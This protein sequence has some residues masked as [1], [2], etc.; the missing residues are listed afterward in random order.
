MRRRPERRLFT[1]R[2]RKRGRPVDSDDSDDS[3]DEPNDDDD[4]D[5]SLE[6]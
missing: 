2:A 6:N 3:D 4:D 1:A 5:E